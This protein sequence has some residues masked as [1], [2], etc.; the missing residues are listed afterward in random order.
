MNQHKFE[1]SDALIPTISL[2]FHLLTSLHSMCIVKVPKRMNTLFT[3][4]LPTFN[5]FVCFASV[6][7]FV[8]FAVCKFHSYWCFY[9]IQ[10]YIVVNF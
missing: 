2:S 7:I 5:Y 8:H 9:C 4:V 6:I 10:L 3:Q 1:S